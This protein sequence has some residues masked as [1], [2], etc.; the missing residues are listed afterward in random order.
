LPTPGSPISTGLFFCTPRKHLDDA[1]YLFVTPNDRIELPFGSHVCQIA[2]ILLQRFVGRFGILCGH[3]LVSPDLDERL[4]QA[5]SC[6]AELA[7]Q[8]ARRSLVLGRGQQQ[9]LD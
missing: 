2:A 3:P 7:Q 6:Q 8:L 4:H 1:P 9:V 5:V